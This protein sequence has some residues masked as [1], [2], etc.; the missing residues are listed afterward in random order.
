M[1]KDKN[2]EDFYYIFV[3]DFWHS[4]LNKRLYAKDYGKEFFRLKIKNKPEENSNAA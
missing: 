4:K 2:N 1:K 3:R